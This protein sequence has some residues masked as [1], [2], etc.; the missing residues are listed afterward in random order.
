[1]SF[2]M[3]HMEPRTFV[4]KGKNEILTHISLMNSD[5]QSN[6]LIEGIMVFTVDINVF[7]RSGYTE[8]GK[9]KIHHELF[10]VALFLIGL[11]CISP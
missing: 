6:H 7:K 5:V 3:I 10:S 11:F 9:L 8:N 1:M 2:V 4:S